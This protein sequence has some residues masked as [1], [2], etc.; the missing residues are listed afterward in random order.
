MPQGLIDRKDRKD[1]QLVIRIRKSERDIFVEL[2][3]TLDT[4]AAREIR[5]FIREFTFAHADLANVRRAP[6]SHGRQ[7]PAGKQKKKTRHA[8]KK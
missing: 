4:S 6:D 1:G 5:R 3:D 2:C 7:E 8:K